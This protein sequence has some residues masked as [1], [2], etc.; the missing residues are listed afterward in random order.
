MKRPDKESIKEFCNQM[1]SAAC[2]ILEIKR[3]LV[4]LKRR[5]AVANRK[6]WIITKRLATLTEEKT[7]QPTRIDLIEQYE[8][9]N[10]AVEKMAIEDKNLKETLRERYQTASELEIDWRC[11]LAR[12]FIEIE[13]QRS[14]LQECLRGRLENFDWFCMELKRRH[15]RWSLD[16]AIQQEWIERGR[17]SRYNED[18]MSFM[19]IWNTPWC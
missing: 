14:P 3:E 1:D 18:L 5:Q 15:A 2:G 19:R 9:E 16:M 4:E 13:S 12:D 6:L 10:A 7:G 11:E 17:L 8:K